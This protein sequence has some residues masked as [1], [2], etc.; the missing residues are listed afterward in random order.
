MLVN[1]HMYTKINVMCLPM[2]ETYLFYSFMLTVETREF[3][4]HTLAHELIVLTR[5]YSSLVLHLSKLCL[6]C[7]TPHLCVN[8]PLWA[9]CCPLYSDP[10]AHSFS[11]EDQVLKDAIL[12]SNQGLISEI[13]L[14][15]FHLLFWVGVSQNSPVSNKYLLP[16]FSRSGII[17]LGFSGIISVEELVQKLW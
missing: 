11:W 1:V 6:F 2:C 12:R 15:N 10:L 17:R 16:I 5:R 13:P 9:S 14:L 4:F 3:R 8:E 7:E